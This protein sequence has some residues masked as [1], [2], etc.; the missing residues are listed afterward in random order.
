LGKPHLKKLLNLKEKA[1]EE[2]SSL[3]KCQF[4]I[5]EPEKKRNFAKGAMQ[6]FQEGK[7]DSAD[8]PRER[9]RGGREK[10]SS[11]RTHYTPK[12]G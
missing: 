11:S 8:S 12:Q 9:K 6:L 2:G 4:N 3:E 5:G 7:I 10:G 1:R